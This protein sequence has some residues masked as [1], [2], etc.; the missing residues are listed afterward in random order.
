[1][2]LQ[3]VLIVSGLLV[4][5]FLA[6]GVFMAYVALR[7]SPTISRVFEEK[8]LF[9]PLRVPPEPG[10]EEVRF[11][12]EDGLE[13]AGTYLKAEGE[14][15]IGVFVFCHEY[16]SNRWSCQP[17]TAELRRL[18]YDVFSF[19]FRSHGE[20][21]EEP[22]YRPLQ[23]VTDH[24]LRDLRAAL[25]YLR[26]RPDRDEAGF[27]LFGVSRGGSTSL[28]VAPGEPDVWGVITDG[29]FPTRG[30]ML[31]YIIRWAEI[32]VSNPGLYRRMPKAVYRTAAWAGRV[33]SER[34]LNCRYPDVEKAVARLS[35]RPWLMIH[36]GKDNYIAPAIVQELFDR[37]REPREIWIVPGAKHNRCLEVAREAYAARLNGFLARYAPR[38]NRGPSATKRPGQ[39]PKGLET[40]PPRSVTE[41]RLI[42]ELVVMK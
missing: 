32:Y 39:P 25:A 36:G 33:R 22:S 1:M 31:A 35:P 19:D 28:V 41:P 11:R 42:E 3:L 14:G 16:L 13:L 30:M 34:R 21:D 38:V 5:P 12:T 29:A 6:L 17:Y 40:A 37:A 26:T 24:E 9:L 23:W 4:L 8:P 27:G 7:Y 18:G 15:R 2:T 20:S 10:G